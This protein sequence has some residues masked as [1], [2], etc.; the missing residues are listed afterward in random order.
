MAAPQ[1]TPP[2]MYEAQHVSYINNY[3]PLGFII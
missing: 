3:L 1:V 2:C